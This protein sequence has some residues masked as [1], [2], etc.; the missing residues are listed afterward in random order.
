MCSELPSEISTMISP[1]MS[2]IV[3]NV[4]EIA[5]GVLGAAAEGA[6]AH[7]RQRLQRPRP[8]PIPK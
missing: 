1:R 5:G 7:S 4:P 8:G 6:G 3:D 2:K